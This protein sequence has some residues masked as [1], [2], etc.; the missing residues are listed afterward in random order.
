MSLFETVTATKLEAECAV[1]F[2]PDSFMR[3]AGAVP[4]R[5]WIVPDVMP[6]NFE[7]YGALITPWRTAD[8]EGFH[9]PGTGN[10]F[11]GIAEGYRFLPPFFDSL[12]L[13]RRSTCGVSRAAV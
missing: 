8:D 5:R 4:P 2:A 7:A 9:P 13:S 6:T 10:T 1:E 3:R 12:R 11:M